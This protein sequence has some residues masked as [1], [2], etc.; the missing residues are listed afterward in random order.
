MK[1]IYHIGLHKTATT[2]LQQCYFSRHPHLCLVNNYNKPW[3]DPFLHY[4]ITTPAG[5][6]DAQA[7]RALLQKKIEENP[8]PSKDDRKPAIISAERLSGHPYSGGHDRYEIMN[9]IKKVSPDARILIFYRDQVPMLKSLYKQMVWQGYT[10]TIHDL[11]YGQRWNGKGFDVSYLEYDL[12]LDAYFESFGKSN[13]LAVKFEDFLT[14]KKGTLAKICSFFEVPVFLDEKTLENKTGQR[15]N[16]QTIPVRRL[17]NKFRKTEYLDSP[18]FVLPHRISSLICR[19]AFF[20]YKDI[21]INEKDRK[22]LQQYFQLPNERLA[23][24]LSK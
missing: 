11:L 14:D 6:F 22:F 12:L 7:G 3:Q 17:L 24:I 23:G 16:D 21:E 4:L 5:K 13:V 18:V 20:F 9:R 15:S 1:T 19:C 2:W 10:G 8:P